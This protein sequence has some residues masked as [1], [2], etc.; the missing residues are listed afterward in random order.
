MRRY[1]NRYGS[2]LGFERP[3]NTVRLPKISKRTTDVYIQYNAANRIDNIA[4][5]YYG[6][7]EYYWVILLANGYATEFDIVEG[8]IIRIPYPL[9]P[10][11]DE[12]K[13]KVRK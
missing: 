9:E 7:P 13:E 1:S 4:N 10:V 6:F 8:D 2:V 3:S 12:I 11:V 5:R